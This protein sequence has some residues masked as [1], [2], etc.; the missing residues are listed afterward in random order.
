MGHFLL[1]HWRS[2]S[3][4]VKQQ[5]KEQIWKQG[6][7]SAALF[8]PRAAGRAATWVCVSRLHFSAEPF[9]RSLECCTGE[10]FQ[11]NEEPAAAMLPGMEQA[12]ELQSAGASSHKAITTP[13]FLSLRKNVQENS[14]II[15]RGSC[16]QPWKPLWG[17]LYI[18][19][20][21][22]LLLV[23]IWQGNY[24]NHIACWQLLWVWIGWSEGPWRVRRWCRQDSFS[25]HQ[26]NW[27]E[28]VLFNK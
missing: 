5:Q 1:E 2:S 23:L 14:K 21:P 22:D 25:E 20:Q 11:W 8:L 27:K 4:D 19:F 24:F 18:R 28:N 9:H 26:Y 6:F 7:F 12:K 17:F 13:T 16:L 10:Q 3:D 15:L